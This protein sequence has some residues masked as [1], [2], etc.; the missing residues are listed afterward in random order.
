MS[1]KYIRCEECGGFIGSSCC[2]TLRQEFLDKLSEQ[3]GFP[4]EQIEQML[5]RGEIYPIKYSAG[6]PDPGDCVVEE[7]SLCVESV[8]MPS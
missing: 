1:K 4:Q 8:K 5:A 3:L 6:K 7:L 2:C